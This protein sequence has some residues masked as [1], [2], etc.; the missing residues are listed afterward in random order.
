MMAAGS[1]PRMM[2]LALPLT[3]MSCAQRSAAIHPPAPVVT[4]L[5]RQIRNAV[6]AGNGD[7]LLRAIR[8]RLIEHPEDLAARLDLGRAYEAR[9]YP[10]LA[11]EHYRLAAE[12]FPESAEAHLQLARSLHAAHLEG[13][14]ARAFGDF[15]QAYP[16]RSVV[17]ASWLGILRDDAGDWKSGE[18]AHRQAIEIALGEGQDKDYLHNNLGYCLLQQG[19][20]AEAAAEFRA[21]LALNRGSEIARDNLGIALAEDSKA[22]ILHWQSVSEPAAAHSNMAAMLIEQHRYPEARAEIAR[23]LGYNRTHSAALAN[24]KLV[25]E[26]DGKPAIIPVAAS[27]QG[28]GARWKVALKRWFAAPVQAEIA[29]TNQTASR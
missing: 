21:A 14:A 1:F 27:P 22:A 6:D 16:Q 19:R 17:Y 7:Y 20:K 25:S 5:D 12:R 9:N 8:Q 13:D 29:S 18:T 2:A 11:L 15:L 23:A 26:L 3:L 4:A 28:W 24:L 10:E